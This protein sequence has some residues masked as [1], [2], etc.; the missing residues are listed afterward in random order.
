MNCSEEGGNPMSQLEVTIKVDIRS[1]EAPSSASEEVERLEP[2][3]FRLV[4]EGAKELDIDG[5]EQALL[6]V[7][8][9]ALRDALSSHLEASAKKKPKTRVCWLTGG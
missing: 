1:T 6:Q 5:L 7:N 2:G 3:H 4:L 8:Y 9:P